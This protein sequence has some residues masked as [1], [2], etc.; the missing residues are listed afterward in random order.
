MY[1]R[2]TID[3]RKFRHNIE[4]VK[5]VMDSKNIEVFAVS[6]VF[7]GNPMIA[8]EYEWAGLKTIGESRIDNLK[9]IQ[10][11][12]MQK[13]LLRLPM[14][15]EIPDLIEYADISLNSEIRTLELISEEALRRGFVHEVILMIDFG[16][17]REGFY[18]QEELFLAVERSLTLDG[19]RVIGI[20]T[21]LTCFGAVIPT[22]DHMNK[23]VAIKEEIE[24]RFGIEI[25][26]ISGGNS[27]SYYLLD[28]ED[29]PKEINNLRIGEIFVCGNETAFSTR[30][31]DTYDDVFKLEAEIVELKKKPSLPIGESGVDAFGNKPYYEDKGDMYR[32][33]CAVGRQDVGTDGLMLIDEGIEILGSSSDHMILDMTHA[34]KNYV[35]GDT[36]QFKLK[37]GGILGVMTSEY[38]RK[39]YINSVDNTDEIHLR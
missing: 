24:A 16:D 33:I 32:A 11:L 3:L 12:D 38:I 18:D 27:S 20:G 28:K 31:P 37:Y 34:K 14:H 21:N 10:G 13:V 30:V 26:Y 39:I 25:K 17:L 29:F 7:S 8:K 22:I 6:K 5:K 9:K 15:S 23:L 36:I 4:V 35:V 2:V 19:V 1:P